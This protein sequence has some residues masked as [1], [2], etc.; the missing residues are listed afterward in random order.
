M[1]AAVLPAPQAPVEIRDVAVPRPGEGEV[2]VKIESSGI[3]HSD[4]FLASSPKLPRTPL[5]LGHEGVGRI[6]ELGAGVSSF[7]LGDRVGI[8][9]LHHSC[10][11]CDFCREG[12][13]NF[14]LKQV[15]TGYHVDGALAEYAVGAANFVARIPDTLPNVQA[16]PLCCAGL[17]AYKAVTTAGLKAGEWIVLFGAGGLG[18]IG[19][20][21][22]KQQGLRVAVVDVAPDK[23]EL[24]AAMGADLTINGMTDKPH[25]VMAQHGGASAAITF[26]GSLAAIDQAFPTLR[27]NGILVLIGLSTKKFELPV[28]PTVLQGLRISG[29]FVGTPRDLQEIVDMAASGT[30]RVHTE[31]CTIADVPAAMEKMRQGTLN[32]RMVVQF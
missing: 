23:L 3:C 13:E 31:T 5:I 16:A 22:A 32:G 4:V 8:A 18:H 1:Q 24:A 29:V 21:L 20:Q 10:G 7:Q 6:V 12:R 15:Q 26:T 30:P 14:C 11:T 9:F 27:P 25:K 2:L 17:T 28:I 19:I